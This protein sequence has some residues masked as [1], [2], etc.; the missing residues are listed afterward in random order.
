MA[1]AGVGLVAAGV[2]KALADVVHVAG[3]DGGTGAS[4]L[5]SIKNAGAPW[6]LGLAETQQTLVSEG[7]R[8]RIRLRVDGGL[9]TGRD[10]VAAALLGADEVSFGTALL[11]A[12]G[13]LMVRSCHLDTC[14]VGIATQRPE[15][16]SKFAATPA[17]VEA[18]LLHL[19]EDVRRHLA[20]LGLRGFGE[21]VGRVECLR[22]RAPRD[23]REGALDPSPLLRRAGRVQRRTGAAQQHAQPGAELGVRLAV[24]AAPALETASLVELDLA[25][26]TVIVLSAPGSAATI[27][28]RYG[29]K[30]PP[31]RV[32]ARLDGLGRTELRRVPHRGRS[33]RADR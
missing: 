17:H 7:L 6:E 1:E 26:T 10:V 14:P 22:R 21:A 15:L 30:P 8:S 5:S 20:A 16:R 27:G 31:G 12:E 29:A 19:A 25:V 32:R 33:P 2:V 18:Y 13:C 4:P 3:C 9:K 24:A 23:A 28:G 11:L